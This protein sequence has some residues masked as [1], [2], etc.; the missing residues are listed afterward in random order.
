MYLRIIIT[1][2]LI[3]LLLPMVAHSS[4]P[5]SESDRKILRIVVGF[6]AGAAADRVARYFQKRFENDK[7][8]AV[9]TYLPGADGIVAARAV[10]AAKPNGTTIFVNA[11]AGLLLASALDSQTNQLV[12]QLDPAMT[13]GKFTKVFITK[14]SNPIQN[15]N[16]LTSY[17]KNKNVNVGGL[18]N[19]VMVAN[20]VFGKN[21]RVT[22]INYVGDINTVNDILNGSL[23]VGVVSYASAAGLIASNMLTAIAVT[24]DRAFNGVPSLRELG[25]PVDQPNY[26]NIYFPPNTPVDIRDRLVQKLRGYINDQEAE[27]L[28]KNEFLIRAPQLTVQEYANM[29]NS[30]VKKYK[31]L[32]EL[33]RD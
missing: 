14:K 29:H 3:A 20:E 30:E 18:R 11:T 15:W 12:M 9:V 21:N 1:T 26:Y 33:Y 22:T 19:N 16:Q 23:D 5:E 25:V 10:V 28:Y 6:P 2:L 13:I 4:E 31:H 17:M 24:N 27:N 32:I 7:I 8:S